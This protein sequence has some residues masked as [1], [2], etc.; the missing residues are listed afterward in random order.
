M[1]TPFERLESRQTAHCN[2]VY[3]CEAGCT[4]RHWNQGDEMTPCTSCGGG[5]W[6][7]CPYDNVMGPYT[8]VSIGDDREVKLLRIPEIGDRLI[9][10][11]QHITPGTY[12]VTGT[13]NGLRIALCGPPNSSQPAFVVTRK[14]AHA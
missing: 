3:H 9:L 5:Q 6:F 8:T 2:A 10:I 11:G 14:A 12:T 1:T 13:V 4:T 7:Y